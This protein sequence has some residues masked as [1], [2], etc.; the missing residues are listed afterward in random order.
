MVGKVKVKSTKV[1]NEFELDID[2]ANSCRILIGKTG[3]EI[4]FT[5]QTGDLTTNQIAFMEEVAKVLNKHLP[6]NM[7]PE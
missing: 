2:C 3:N 1:G 5:N 7:I 4:V 6:L